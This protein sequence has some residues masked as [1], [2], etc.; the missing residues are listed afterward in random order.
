MHTSEFIEL[1]LEEL[2]QNPGLRNYHRIINNPSSLAFR[3]A[4]YQQRLQYVEDMITTSN[5]SILDV[6]CGYGTTSIMLALMGH[7]VT[8]TTLEYYYDQI[9]GRL[10]FWTKKFDLEHLTFKYENIFDSNYTPESF[11]YIVAQD[12]LHHLE[13]IGEALNVLRGVLKPGGKLIITEENG[14]NI[15]CNIKHFRER[16]FK[17][18]IN[19]YDEG[20][21]KT[22][23]FGNENTRGLKKWEGLLQ[24]AHFTVDQSKTQ[25][26]RFYMPMAY[27]R[28]PESLIYEKEQRLWPKSSVL[29]EF[30]FFGINF[31]AVRSK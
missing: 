25:Y 10:D 26:I 21:G 18:V 8:G 1:F 12:T 9:M 16:G 22:I 17:R 7:K 3:K 2:E 27:H 24:R 29:R 15:I 5:A 13:P 11:D 28:H 23:S 6:G 31:T 4:Y 30:F 19:L 20:L 14:N